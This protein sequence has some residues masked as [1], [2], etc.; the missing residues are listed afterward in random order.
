MTGPQINPPGNR[1]VLKLPHS[2]KGMGGTP[3][4][5]LILAE[6]GQN[7]ARPAFEDIVWASPVRAGVG[8]KFSLSGD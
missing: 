7:P 5:G 1:F 2:L 6:L 3:S 4:A 8:G